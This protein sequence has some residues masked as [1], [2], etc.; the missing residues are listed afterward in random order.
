[1]DPLILNITMV[2]RM[3]RMNF[4]SIVLKN[5]VKQS[6]YRSEYMYK[7]FFSPHDVINITWR[8]TF[9]TRWLHN[10]ANIAGT[11]FVFNQVWKRIWWQ[12]DANPPSPGIIHGTLDQRTIETGNAYKLWLC[13]ENKGL[14]I[15]FLLSFDGIRKWRKWVNFPFLLHNKSSTSLNRCLNT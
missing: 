6:W 4:L 3:L 7:C 2:P 12:Q 10:N 5:T 11:I 15:F 9:F 13:K 8:Y 14:K 1:M